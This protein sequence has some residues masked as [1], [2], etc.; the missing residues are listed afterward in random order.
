MMGRD[1]ENPLNISNTRVKFP[2]TGT[3]RKDVKHMLSNSFDVL[4]KALR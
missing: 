1:F 2:G 4:K 3:L